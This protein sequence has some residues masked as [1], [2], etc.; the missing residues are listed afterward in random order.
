MPFDE[1][2]ESIVAVGVREAVV[3]VFLL[4]ESC[5]VSEEV[6]LVEAIDYREVIGVVEYGYEILLAGYDLTV[7]SAL[8]VDRQQFFEFESPLG[9]LEG[10]E[11]RIRKHLIITYLNGGEQA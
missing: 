3:L 7:C 6:L 1:L 10:L 5:N 4:K 8:L 9:R 2:S 11:L